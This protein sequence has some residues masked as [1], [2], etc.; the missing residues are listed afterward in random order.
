[1]HPLYN[2]TRL[3]VALFLCLREDHLAVNA[4]FEAASRPFYKGYLF[5]LIAE[6]RDYL[7]RQP[8]GAW[9]VASLLA[10]KYLDF[11]L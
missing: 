8:G 7:L 10:I 11:H 4:N 3:R 6:L 2:F 5:Q 9:P 1:V